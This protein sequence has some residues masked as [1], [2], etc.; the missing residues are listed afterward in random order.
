[1][2]PDPFT[3]LRQADP[4]PAR[5]PYDPSRATAL[6]DGAV[7]TGTPTVPT[8]SR[9]P[10]RRAARSWQTAGVALGAVVL[11][12]GG[13]AAYAVLHQPARSALGLA[14]A[15]G[16]SQQEFQ[17]S[18]ALSSFL[19]TRSGDPVAD[20]AAEYQLRR[21]PPPALRGYSTGASHISVVPADWTVPTT[22]QPLG[23]DFRSDPARLEL[24]QR[25]DDVI[26]GPSSACHSADQVQALVQRDLTE[27]GLTAWTIDRLDQ[28]GRADGE[29]W[30]ALALLDVTGLQTVSI[31]GLPGPANGQAAPTEPFGQLLQSLR[32]DA[33]RC[34]SLPEAQERVEQAVTAAGFDLQDATI[35]TIVDA[36]ASC[37]VADMPSSGSIQVVLRGP[38][39]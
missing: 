17:Q 37:T 28:A 38:A 2:I 30:C 7:T 24:E 12:G 36:S 4:A 10:G 31:Q 3:L 1:M 15:A 25:L 20:C 16:T 39:R 23:G 5:A 22:W 9:R 19:R 14:C 21:I 11:A 35:T 27:L 18:G 6:L 13:G 26:D 33:G 8:T 32:R 34:R 29:D